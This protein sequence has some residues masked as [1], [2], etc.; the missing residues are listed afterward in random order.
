MRNAE[1]IRQ[2]KILKRI[3]KSRYVTAA[4]LAEEHD[5]AL[6]TIRRDIEALQEAGF[7]L[8]DDKESGKKVWRLLE[9]YSQKAQAGFTMSEMAALYFGRHLMTILSGAP[10]ADD[11]VAFGRHQGD[12]AR[13]VGLHQR[14]QRGGREF[15]DRRADENPKVILL[16]LKLPKVDGIEVLRRVKSDGRT[17]AIPVVVLTSNRTRDVHDALVDARDCNAM[18]LPRSPSTLRMPL[19]RR[20]KIRLR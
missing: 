13:L 11:L 8:Y 5:V 4:D 3:E 20:T 7:P 12:V 9:G 6:R 14:L 19:S 16:D 15:A 10:F 1:V 17:K 18:R 2:W